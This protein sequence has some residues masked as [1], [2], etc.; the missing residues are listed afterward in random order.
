M[1]AIA[2]SLGFDVVSLRLELFGRRRGIESSPQSAG[3]EPPV[4]SSV[5]DQKPQAF[6]VAK[7][8]NR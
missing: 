4:D 5:A 6:G 3:P 2:D 1:H 7:G 8:A